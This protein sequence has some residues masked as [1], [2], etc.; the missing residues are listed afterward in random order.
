MSRQPRGDWRAEVGRHE[1]RAARE[2]FGD[3]M[4]LFR[5][6]LRVITLPFWLPFYLLGVINQRRAVKAFVID[7]A[8][9]RL[10]NDELIHE[11]TL[12]WVEGDPETYP[13]GEYDPAFRIPQAQPPLQGYNPERQGLVALQEQPSIVA[14]LNV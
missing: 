13:L 3:Q 8:R 6:L 5:L 4:S 7:R 14:N 9:N 1:G 10:V 12:A 2:A 11:I